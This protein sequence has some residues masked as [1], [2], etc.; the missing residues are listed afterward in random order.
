M[1]APR[2]KK[3]PAAAAKLAEI[4]RRLLAQYGPQKCFLEHETPCQLLV[5]TILSAHCTD[6]MVNRVTAELFKTRSR[7]EDFASME[8]AELEP[9]IHSCGYYRA[10]AK[11]IVGAS[12]VLVEKFHSEMPCT[13]E[14]LTS[15]PG[16]GRKTA[17]VV[18]A[19]AFGVPGLPVDTHVTR[20]A[21]LLGVTASKDP[22]RIEAD[23]CASLA[24]ER[25][26]EFSH[27]LIVHGRTVC[28]AR[29]PKCADCVLADLCRH[30]TAGRRR[31]KA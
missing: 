27:L 14:E 4:D 1:A 11:N 24:P 12:R 6:R 8:P 26:G 2:K 16:V 9:L 13:M 22:V 25:W 15:L 17:N 28:P 21:G 18:L 23:L 7:P 31:K 29:R 3:S 20:I 19:D 10:K 30:H 5:A